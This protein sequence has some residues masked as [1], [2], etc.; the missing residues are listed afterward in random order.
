MSTADK[1]KDHQ[2][3]IEELQERER[4][5]AQLVNPEEIER[6]INKKK[7][8]IVKKNKFVTKNVLDIMKTKKEKLYADLS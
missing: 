3:Q 4:L 1:N 8:A 6:R 7:K 2:K 5:E